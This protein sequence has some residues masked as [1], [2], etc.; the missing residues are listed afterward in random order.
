VTA[1]IRSM[2]EPD[3][4]RMLASVRAEIGRREAVLAGHGGAIDNYWRARELQPA[5]PR[6]PRIVLV[7]DDT[8]RVLD[9]APGFLGEL[10]S[11]AAAGRPLGAPRVV[12]PRPPRQGSSTSLKDGFDLRIS[13]RQ[14]EAADSAELLGVPDA[15]TIP[16]ALRGRGMIACTRGEPTTPRA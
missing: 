16:A 1:V 2:D 12:A 10:V 14:D 11:V 6:L 4:A 7:F 8:D 5:L 13:L 3:A 9:T 15:I